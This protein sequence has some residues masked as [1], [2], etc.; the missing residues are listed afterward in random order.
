MRALIGLLLLL[1]LLSPARA[2]DEPKGVTDAERALFAWFDGLGYPDVTKLPLVRYRS[3]YGEW[4]PAIADAGT[5][6]VEHAFLVADDDSS[7]QVFTSTLRFETV[8]KADVEGRARG[9]ARS[10][11]SGTS[12]GPAWRSSGTKPPLARWYDDV[13]DPFKCWGWSVPDQTFRLLVLAALARGGLGPLAHELCEHALGREEARASDDPFKGLKESLAGEAFEAA[14]ERIGDAGSPLPDVARSL[15]QV[16]D[17]FPRHRRTKR[18]AERARAFEK[19][20]GEKQDGAA[21]DVGALVETLRRTP[22]RTWMDD[23]PTAV[24][25]E[26]P[27]GALV[28]RGL[29]AAPT[30]AGLLDDESPTRTLRIYFSAKGQYRNQTWPTTLGELASRYLT[31]W[32]PGRFGTR[33]VE[34]WNQTRTAASRG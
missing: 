21:T 7:F 33:M 5:T 20:A 11:I 29:S 32:P 16:C 9:P 4:Y 3:A 17:S 18:M 31:R 2:D 15:R 8:R 1:C 14:D 13:R 23:E 22:R 19:W 12:C 30:L 28:T 26:T 27:F 10:L 24:E 25:P 34:D 6:D